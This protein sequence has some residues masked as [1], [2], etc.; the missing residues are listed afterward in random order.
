MSTAYHA[1]GTKTRGHPKPEHTPGPWRAAKMHTLVGI[2]AGSGASVKRIARVYKAS[3]ATGIT[4][5]EGEANAQLIAAAPN[6][7]AACR[8]T[9]DGI[10]HA[11]RDDG[12]RDSMLHTLIP[13]LAAAIARAEGG[14]ARVH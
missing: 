12:W 11:C 6:L 3:T 4:D 10:D 13:R 9:L 7:L 5:A 8:A 2:R 1:D 14:D